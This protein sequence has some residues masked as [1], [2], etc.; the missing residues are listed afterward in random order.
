MRSTRVGCLRVGSG[1][2]R[3]LVAEAAASL[4]REPGVGQRRR[5]TR[6]GVSRNRAYWVDSGFADELRDSGSFITSREC[7]G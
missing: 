4:R 7:A 3:F 1:A 6:G 2:A 5:I